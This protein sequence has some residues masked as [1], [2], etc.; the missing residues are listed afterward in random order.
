M[1]RRKA[2]TEGLYSYIM[3]KNNPSPPNR[4][5][6]LY[7]REP[8]IRAHPEHNPT[9]NLCE[10][11]GLFSEQGG[12]KSADRRQRESFEQNAEL[13]GAFVKKT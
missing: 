1:A 5:S 11:F 12:E 8:F 7:T 10:V 2:V 6:S 4:R 9:P 13:N 3:Y